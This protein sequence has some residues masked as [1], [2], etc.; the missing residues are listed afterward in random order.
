[1]SAGHGER[2]TRFELTLLWKRKNLP[3]RGRRRFGEHR[4]GVLAYVRRSSEKIRE[5]FITDVTVT[6]YRR[7]CQAPTR[8]TRRGLFP[9]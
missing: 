7:L 8:C 3:A 9:V 6:G 5:T 4:W 1:M 2:S